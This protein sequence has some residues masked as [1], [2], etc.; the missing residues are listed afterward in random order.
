MQ[1]IKIFKSVESEVETLEETVNQWLAETGAKV[2]QL[3]GNIA[4]QT[5]PIDAGASGGSFSTGGGSPL[6]FPPSDILLIVLY[7]MP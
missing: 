1:Q 3:V 5:E 7:E 4:P 6:R 2:I